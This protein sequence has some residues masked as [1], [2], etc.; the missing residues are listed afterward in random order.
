MARPSRTRS[1]LPEVRAAACKGACGARF[2]DEQREMARKFDAAAQLAAA[3]EARRRAGLPER[4]E[5]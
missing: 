2:T 5:A 4:T 3:R 1:V